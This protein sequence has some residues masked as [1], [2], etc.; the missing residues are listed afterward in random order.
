MKKNI[1]E[2]MNAACVES[3]NIAREEYISGLHHSTERLRNCQ[4]KVITT[5]NYRFLL[6]YNTIVC[7]IDLQTGI[8][9]DVLRYVYGYTATSAQH[10]AVSSTTSR[11]TAVLR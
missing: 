1:Q 8:S 9:F 6:S 10:I 5:D 11:L 7:F 2:A 3:F 4:A